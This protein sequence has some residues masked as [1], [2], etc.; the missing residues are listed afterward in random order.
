MKKL[1]FSAIA[2]VAFSFAGMANDAN[3]NAETLTVVLE[4][5]CVEASFAAADAV[6]ALL[7]V[8]LSPLEEGKLLLALYDACDAGR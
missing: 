1:V 2:L 8:Q 4:D 7:G 3:E 6:Q 5:E